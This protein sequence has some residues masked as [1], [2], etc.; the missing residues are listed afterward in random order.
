M[1]KKFYALFATLIIAGYGYAGFR[2]VELTP[3]K[4]GYAPH[5]A[6]GRG[7]QGGSRA[8]WYGG[9]RGGK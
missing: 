7:S 5:G 8:F 9:Y 1:M 2:G 4:K 3:T 6:T